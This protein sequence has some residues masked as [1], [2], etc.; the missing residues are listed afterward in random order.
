MSEPVGGAHLDL[1]P[2]T[3]GFAAS[4]P[5]PSLTTSWETLLSCDMEVKALR[6]WLLSHSLFHLSF[7]SP[8][9]M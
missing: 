9:V 1:Q 2:Y 7:R 5:Y 6:P 4:R 3:R 8:T